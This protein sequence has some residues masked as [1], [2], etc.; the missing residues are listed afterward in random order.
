MSEKIDTIVDVCD[1]LSSGNAELAASTLHERYPFEPIAKTPSKITKLKS[2]KIFE[3]DSYL[4][5]YTGQR[6]IFPGTML[7]IS[8]YLPDEFPNHPNWKTEHT[9]FAYYELWPVIDHVL[10]L[11]RR[12]DNADD[13][14]VTTSAMR[15]A[16]KANYT[17]NELGWRLLEV[18]TVKNWDGLT[19][20]FQTQISAKPQFL[21]DPYVRRWHE[22]LG[23]SRTPPNN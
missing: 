3:R 17:L 21:D 20:W 14:L 2:I 12:G 19:T 10:P 15:N 13:N 23:Q 5:R 18:P 16:A 6:L 9:H 1:A 11:T 4:D 22:S 8:K 7:L